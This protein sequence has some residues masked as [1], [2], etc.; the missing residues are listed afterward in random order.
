MHVLV[1]YDVED[2]RIRHRISEVCKDYGLVRTQ[3]SAFRGVLSSTRRSEL[4]RRLRWTL[5]AKDGKIEVYSLCDWDVR[6]V[7]EIV[8]GQVG[9]PDVRLSRGWGYRDEDM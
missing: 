1:I 8:V 3:Y 4:V 7:Q 5:G 9:R 6:L 2:D